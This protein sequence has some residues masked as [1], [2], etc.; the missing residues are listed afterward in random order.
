MIDAHRVVLG[1]SVLLR[2]LV[3]GDLRRLVKWFS[4][5]QINRFL[6]RTAGVTLAD[7]ERWFRE[8][9]RKADEQIFAIEVDG[10]HVGNVGLHKVDP[11]NRK[12]ELGILIGEKGL[13]SKGLG[14]D[15]IRAA[16]RYA[17]DI[18]G[19][20]KVSLDVLDGNHRAVRAYEKV[21][22]V[23]EG[24]HRQDI[25]RDGRFFDVVRMGVLD[26]EFRARTSPPPPV[27]LAS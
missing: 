17:F 23:R 21:G 18:L 11:V 2:P 24:V 13:W 5:P 10:R 1:E 12:A 4:D 19:L 27:P 16:L 25:H 6:G 14:T 22:F 26:T 15:A 8:Y 20:H 3:S 7:E 9:E